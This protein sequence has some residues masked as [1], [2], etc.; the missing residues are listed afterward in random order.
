MKFRACGPSRPTRFDLMAVPLKA[1][2]GRFLLCFCIAKIC[3]SKQP[4]RILSGCFVFLTRTEV[5]G[6]DCRV[7]H[8]RGYKKYC[9]Q[10]FK[11]AG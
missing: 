2:H 3:I 6:E 11:I 1:A 5:F 9:Q 10:Q 8:L 7:K 4:D